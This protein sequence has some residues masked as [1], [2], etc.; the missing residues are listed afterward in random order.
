MLSCSAW[1]LPEFFADPRPARNSRCASCKPHR[2]AGE[3]AGAHRARGAGGAL[4]QDRDASG[5]GQA[6]R[7]RAPGRPAGSRARG[8]EEAITSLAYLNAGSAATMAGGGYVAGSAPSSTPTSPGVASWPSRTTA[9]DRL[10]KPPDR[11]AGG[12]DLHGGRGHSRLRSPASP[13]A[14]AA[15]A[16]PRRPARARAKP[17]S[18]GAAL[19]DLTLTCPWTAAAIPIVSTNGSRPARARRPPPAPARARPPSRQCRLGRRACSAW[20]A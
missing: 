16:H 20:P 4:L 14:A 17:L 8:G 7:A 10:G 5:G 3:A 15:C 2:L 13:V 11:A 19:G 1:I 18:A 6:V 9:A 12:Q